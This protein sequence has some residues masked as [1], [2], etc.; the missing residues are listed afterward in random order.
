MSSKSKVVVLTG[1][2][3]AGKTTLLN[4]ILTSPQGRR[5]AV[6]VNEFGEIGIDHHLLIA[7][8]QEVVQMSNGC[9]C[10]TVR[11]DLLRSLYDL[12]DRRTEFDTV[13]IETT[14]LAEPGPVLQTLYADERI[15]AECMLTGVVTLVDAK[16]IVTQ[17]EESGEAQE[18][19]AFA[20]LIVLNKTDLVDAE[21]LDRVET[22]VRRL[23]S[24]AAVTRTRNSEIDIAGI[25]SLEEVSFQR[26]ATLKGSGCLG[27]EDHVAHGCHEHGHHHASGHRHLKDI[28]TITILQSGAHDGLKLSRWFQSMMAEHGH[29]ILRMKGIL[30]LWGDPDQFLF[31]GVRSEFEC[32][33][34]RPWAEGEERTNRLVFIGR[35]LDETAIRDG[36]ATS[37]STDNRPA[38]LRPDNF[39]RWHAEASLQ[40]L[41][42]IRFWMRQ[43][44]GYAKTTPILVKDVPCGKPGCPP[45]ETAIL[46]LLQSEPPRLFKVQASINDLTYDHIYDLMENPMPCC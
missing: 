15:R 30:D 19:I 41:E 22:A 36:F 18:Q 7:A 40:R 20:D 6:I 21:A 11:G 32:R 33:P 1:F 17:L 31:Q 28:E 29:R 44:F 25:F 24:T 14:G 13:V 3:G 35:D 42:Q 43:N 34:G 5:V 10:C 46:V 27:E 26:L 9:I 45:I 8:K 39:G 38:H 23:N 16:Y 37:L 4:R 12:L 2:L